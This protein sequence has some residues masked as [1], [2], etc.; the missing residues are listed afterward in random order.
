MSIL[1][2]AGIVVV[3]LTGGVRYEL[4][5]RSSKALRTAG[6]V[7]VGIGGFV[8]A[9]MLFWMNWPFRDFLR[10]NGVGRWFS[11][12]FALTGLIG[13]LPG[14]G[15]LL[16]GMGVLAGLSHCAVEVAG[17][18]IK[19][20]ER[21]GLLRWSWTRKIADM[22]QLYLSCDPAPTDAMDGGTPPSS[23][24]SRIE[25]ISTV[26]KDEK[27]SGLII[28]AAYP[29]TVLQALITELSDKTGLPIVRDED[30]LD[31]EDEA[32]LD[33]VE[34]AAIHDR[35][36]SE[37]PPKT[38]IVLQNLPDGV[39]LSVPPSGLWKGTKGIFLF[40]IAWDVICTGIILVMVF[41]IFRGGSNGDIP[42]V[43]VFVVMA[44]FL[45]IGIAM[46]L[47]AISMGTRRALVAA[48]KGALTV[49][50]I[51]PFRTREWQFAAGEVAAIRMGASGT[52]VNDTPVMEL[53]IVDRKGKKVGFLS[54]RTN[55]ELMW[56]AAVLRLTL[57]IRSEPPV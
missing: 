31:D 7:L 26:G 2:T 18:E 36:S 46:T 38:D 40:V 13:L 41:G 3:P 30:F 54:Q 15:M 47:G 22:T 34:A 29:R 28:A 9:F 32:N 10:E 39:G 51:S 21:C 50:Q 49:R 43:G 24:S 20:I 37:H 52:T 45:A 12:A 5:H 35:L 48:T 42:P 4:P 56:L 25:G 1:R 11:L 23:R 44:I 57:N 14:L 16:G 6:W 53:Q 55:E 33:P 8:T 17:T 19:L 27:T